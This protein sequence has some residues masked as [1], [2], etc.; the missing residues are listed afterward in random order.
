MTDYGTLTYVPGGRPNTR[1]TWQAVVRPH[2]AI[3]FKRVFPSVSP[4]AS[5]TLTL[6]HSDAVAADLHWFMQR[7]PLTMDDATA[8]RLA[9]SVA[10]N[11]ARDEAV[12]AVLAGKRLDDFDFRDPS[13]E[14]PRDYQTTAADLVTTVRRCVIGDALGLGKTFTGLLTLRN[15]GSLPA[16]LV[17]P[18]HL[19]HQWERYCNRVW[20]TLSTHVARKGTPYDM[21]RY[22]GEPD[23]LIL[24]YAKVAGWSHHLAGHARTV[25][26]DEV[27]DLRRGRESDKGKAAAWIAA[28]AEY[29]VGLTATP[30]YNYGG[31]IHN[32]MSIVAPGALGSRDEFLREW[33]GA[34]WT[35]TRG[36]WQATVADPRALSQHM[37][38]L[39]IYIGRT[40]VDVGRELPYGEAEKVPHYIDA[41]RDVLDRLTGDAVEMARL[42]L[43]KGTDPRERFVVSG[44]FDAR[45]RQ[46]TGL[47]KAPFVA[48]FTRTLLDSEDKVVLWGWHHAVYDVWE[49]R[50][51]KAGVT[52]ARY[53]GRE[54]VA[55]KDDALDRFMRPATDRQAAQVLIMSLRSGAGI[56]GLQGVCH[57]G[58]IGELDWSPKMM[59]QCLGR[60]ARDGQENEVVGYYL[61]AEDGA[62]P[63]MAERLNIKHGQ[64]APIEDPNTPVTSALPDP[65]SRVQ[66]LARDLLRQRGV[67]VPNGGGD[68]LPTL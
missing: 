66:D 40:R 61:M 12:D 36:S 13:G 53:T 3:R 1:P 30:V 6:T 27:Q 5:G 44:E 18:T 55:A 62:D 9:E 38:D 45:L 32:I 2:V 22:G 41:D 28:E 50:L 37:R 57:T 47:A 34:S 24:N 16:V 67:A 17:V 21:T 14:S 29:V 58:V 7:Y 42:I 49:E 65:T 43:D 35:T 46:A 25:I 60:L 52:V 56:D 64:A 59:D 51:R 39:G 31:E 15:P 33:G 11:T 26:F 54:S 48:A 68:T 63:A 19:T 23:V 10:A 8:D 20:P 4:S